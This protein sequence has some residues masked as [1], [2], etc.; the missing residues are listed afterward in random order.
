MPSKRRQAV[1]LD[2]S[3]LTYLPDIESEPPNDACRPTAS[4][5]WLLGSISNRI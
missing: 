3:H 1:L 2:R 4:S 5:E